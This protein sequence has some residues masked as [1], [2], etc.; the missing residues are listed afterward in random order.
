MKSL[1]K[2]KWK[3]FLRINVMSGVGD[4]KCQLKV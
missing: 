3:L 4:I 1:E 2:V